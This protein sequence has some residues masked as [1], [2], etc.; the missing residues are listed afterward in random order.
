M[1]SGLIAAYYSV[2]DNRY[3]CV[4]ESKKDHFTIAELR[5]GKWSP[6]KEKSKLVLPL[7]MNL[8]AAECALKEWLRTH[9]P[10][11]QKLNYVARTLP[12]PEVERVAT[13]LRQVMIEQ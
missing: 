8:F 1:K 3:F 5:S 9:C 2:P 13:P 7:T 4:Y 10:A 11:A 6:I 12:F